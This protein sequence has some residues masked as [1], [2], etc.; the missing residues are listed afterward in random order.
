MG[1]SLIDPDTGREFRLHMPDRSANQDDLVLILNLHGGRS[2]GR[3]QDGYFPAYRLANRFGL[4]VA[5]PTL[6]KAQLTTG[7]VPESEDRH[8]HNIVDMAVNRFGRERLRSFW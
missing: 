2:F 6:S 8:L 4:V 1:E 7:P 5:T 3:W